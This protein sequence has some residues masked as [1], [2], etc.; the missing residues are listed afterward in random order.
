MSPHSL[1]SKEPLESSFVNFHGDRSNPGP[2]G[3]K[4][5]S[6]RFHA[7]KPCM[8]L[9]PRVFSLA[10]NPPF[11]PHLALWSRLSPLS[12]YL[13]L[14][15]PASPLKSFIRCFCL[16]LLIQVSRL[17]RL[18]P[19]WIQMSLLHNESFPKK[20]QVSTSSCQHSQLIFYLFYV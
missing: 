8:I 18:S 14:N 12:F 10:L 9:Q 11:L 19:N 20:H 3:P 2:E 1:F 6:V 4:W 16:S 5:L 7:E 15:G 13:E 17:A